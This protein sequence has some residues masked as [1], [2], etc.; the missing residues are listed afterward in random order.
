PQHRW[1]VLWSAVARIEPGE[2]R[3]EKVDQGTKP[4]ITMPFG[5]HRGQP[6]NRVPDDYLEWLLTIELKPW[7]RSEVSTELRRR[8]CR[9]RSVA[10][11]PTTS[12]G[13][14]D[15]L[16][17]WFRRLSRTWHPDA[18]GTKEAMQALND[19]RVLMLQLLAEEG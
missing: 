4:M 3:A 1:K 19:G 6:I 7:L 10:P 13:V 2:L 15:V 5:K 11:A 18:G 8:E 9:S 17:T 16:D 12:G 14:N